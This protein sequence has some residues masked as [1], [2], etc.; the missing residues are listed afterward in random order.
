MRNRR[1]RKEKIIAHLHRQLN[2]SVVSK[3]QQ[4]ILPNTDGTIRLSKISA[5]PA[6][7]ITRYPVSAHVVIDLKKSLLLT[8]AIIFFE[9]VLFFILQKRIFGLSFVGL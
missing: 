6:F 5:M 2:K 3:T 1:T 8:I 4:D 7:P 9:F